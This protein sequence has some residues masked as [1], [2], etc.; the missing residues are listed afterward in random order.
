M[1][2]RMRDGEP[3]LTILVVD[4][5]PLVLMTLKR[6]LAAEGYKVFETGD[7]KEAPGVLAREAIDVLI[8]DLDMPGMSGL[9]LLAQVRREFPAVVRILLTGAA[10]LGSALDAINKGEVF[11]YL[12]KPWRTEELRAAITDA[13]GRAKEERWIANAASA[14]QRRA[15]LLA[16]IEEAFPGLTR[17]ERSEGDYVVDAQNVARGLEHLG[18]PALLALWKG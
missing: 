18:D 5:D 4:D 13:A 2:E 16:A 1:S 8:S 14:D 15:G 10:T 6:A 3:P 9:A 7:P 17:L 11:R 12:T